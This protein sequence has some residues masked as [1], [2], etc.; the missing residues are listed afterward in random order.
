[1]D[2]FKFA[3]I[4]KPGIGY[5]LGG[6]GDMLPREQFLDA[7]AGQFETYGDELTAHSQTYHV[8]ASDIADWC[9]SLTAF[10][11]S[12]IG[13]VC[14]FDDSDVF[15]IDCYLPHD[16]S[17]T[18]EFLASIKYDEKKRRY[19][20]LDV[21]CK[22]SASDKLRFDKRYHEVPTCADGSRESVQL[23]YYTGI[24]FNPGALKLFVLWQLCPYECWGDR[25]RFA[26]GWHTDTSAFPA[27]DCLMAACQMLRARRM[28]DG[29][30]DNES[31]RR[32]REQSEKLETIAA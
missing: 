16:I 12:R 29:H 27:V 11:R 14:E 24:G 23:L 9:Y 1:M 26:Q 31:R 3:S 30:I 15:N 5:Q 28:V 22:L 19:F 18:A 25:E 7:N 4:S 20:S 17:R 13:G 8:R 2:R 6:M 21:S 10:I 32:K